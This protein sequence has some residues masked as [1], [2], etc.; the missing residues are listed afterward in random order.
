MV[1]NELQKFLVQ[2]KAHK[3]TDKELS[4][5]MKKINIK[6]KF[7]TGLVMF[8]YNDWADFSNKVVQNCRGII[9]YRE[10]FSIACYP[11]DKFN[12]YTSSLAAEIDWKSAVVQEKLDG[13]I[14]KIWFN[15]ITNSWV[16]SSDS[17][18]YAAESRIKSGRK[19]GWLF[20]EVCKSKI[21]HNKLDENKTYM[22]EITS[23]YNKIVINYKE[24]DIWHIGTR[25]NLTQKEENTD[26]GIQKPKTYKIKSLEDAVET[27]NKIS[28]PEDR[29]EGFVVVDKNYNRIKVKCQYYF[30]NK[31][32]MGKLNGNKETILEF[33]DSNNIDNILSKVPEMRNKV[34][35]YSEQLT[36]TRQN[37]E[38]S[39]P[40]CTKLKE[41]YKKLN[42]IERVNQ[43]TKENH[44]ENL[45][46]LLFSYYDS[47]KTIE[48]FI[49]DLDKKKI[50]N[51]IKEYKE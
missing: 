1:K 37:I 16:L 21:D 44:V 12:N 14:L 49:N 10:D 45:N 34:E 29:H 30:D 26:I 4:N 9:L 40:H 23:P 38:K 36:K 41:Q 50:Y 7:E 3:M 5:L 25:N 48:E 27:I 13:Q 20:N 42:Y 47:N 6:V 33:I 51:L 32:L 46:S 39:M 18:I 8:M 11:F 24:T 15:R 31:E 28:I 17:C 19:M 35:Y 22:F 2:N 43:Y